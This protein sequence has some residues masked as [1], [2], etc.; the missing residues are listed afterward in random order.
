MADEFQELFAN[1]YRARRERQ[2][3]ESRAIFFEGVRRAAEQAN[4]PA[5][6]EALCGLA[7]A[8]R[9]IGNCAAA[10]H[11]YANAALLYREIGPPSRLAYALR[12]E[13]DLARELNKPEEAESA[14][15]EAETIYRGLGNDARLDLANTLRGLALVK[16][17]TG[18]A[19]ASKP[20]WT[21]A[22]DLYLRCDVRVGVEKCDQKLRELSGVG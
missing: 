4:R 17:G 12:H 8:E 20:L 11:Q 3:A 5:L 7:Q 22:R 6:A 2:Y 21:E 16:E 19:Q 13:G 9:D 10:H 14:Y 15:R 1:G 18:P